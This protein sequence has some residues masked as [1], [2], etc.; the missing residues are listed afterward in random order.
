MPKSKIPFAWYGGKFNIAPRLIE[1]FPP[2]RVY[3]EPFGGSG[4]IIFCRP[5]PIYEGRYADVLE[6]FNDIDSDIV[7]FFRVLREQRAELIRLVN[8]TPHSREEKYQAWAERENDDDPVT[9]AWR[10]YVN[11]QQGWSGTFGKSWGCDRTKTKRTSRWYLSPLTLETCADRFKQ[12]QLENQSYQTIIEKYDSPETF[13]YCDPPYVDSVRR[14]TDVYLHEFTDDDHRDLV[15]RLLSI[16]GQAMLSGYDNPLYNQPLK[17]WT[18][19]HIKARLTA[20]G[21]QTE[22]IKTRTETIW[23]SYELDNPPE[24]DTDY[25]KEGDNLELMKSLPT[26]SINLIYADPP[27][28][29]GRDFHAEDI[30]YNDQWD[31]DAP[32]PE[33]FEW[34][35]SVSSQRRHY[36]YLNFMIPRLLECQRLL[37]SDGGFFLHCDY[38]ANSILRICLDEIFGNSN[39]RSELIWHYPGTGAQWVGAPKRPRSVYDSILYYGKTNHQFNPLFEP[40][41]EKEIKAMYLHQDSQGNRFRYIRHGEMGREKQFAREDPGRKIGNVW[42]QRWKK[43]V[44]TTGYPT[45]K[46]LALL[47]KIIFCGSN[48]GDVILDPFC[49]TGTALLSARNAKRRWIGF[50]CNPE[51]IAIAKQRLAA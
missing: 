39:Y 19:H 45:Q 25:L 12:V 50:D 36:A 16:Q 34:L 17:A 11:V 44:E 8:D 43:P 47:D 28:N 46:P 9:R 41:S 23:M 38:R 27:F 40:Y 33:G 37:R 26:A 49:G 35:D 24:F 2:H 14:D 10:F 18:K 29:T 3:V 31:K 42:T 4:A 22:R 6:V 7:N 51:A 1:R 15:D 21:S 30:G 5:A 13:F 32:L 20:A 48:V